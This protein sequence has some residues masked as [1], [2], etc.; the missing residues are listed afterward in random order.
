MVFMVVQLAS[1][2]IHFL[3][4]CRFFMVLGVFGVE[5]VEDGI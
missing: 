1:P 4:G 3:G 2:F 5:G